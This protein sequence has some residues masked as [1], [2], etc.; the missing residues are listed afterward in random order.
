[1]SFLKVLNLSLRWAKVQ[2]CISICFQMRIL[3]IYLYRFSDFMFEIFCLDLV[4]C[5]I[6]TLTSKRMKLQSSALT[7]LKENSKTFKKL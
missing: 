7:H 3:L 2:L 4:R 5:L 6:T 1:M